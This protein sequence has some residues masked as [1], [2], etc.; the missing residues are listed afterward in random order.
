MYAAIR[1]SVYMGEVDQDK[2][3][4]KVIAEK[5][6]PIGSLFCLF[7][8]FICITLPFP[9][10]LFLNRFLYKVSRE[11]HTRI[12]HKTDARIFLSGVRRA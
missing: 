12:C 3:K 8:C 9:A 10:V 2:R 1:S 5:K 11:F 4:Q 6:L 7:V